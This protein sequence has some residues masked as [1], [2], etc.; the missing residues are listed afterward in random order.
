MQDRVALPGTGK[1]NRVERSKTVVRELESG[2]LTGDEQPWPLANR[3]KGVSNWT[4]LDRFR[5]RS[6]N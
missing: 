1:R 4:K 2:M 3:R 6:D 5:A